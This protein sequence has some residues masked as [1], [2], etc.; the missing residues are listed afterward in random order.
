MS[1][2]EIGERVGLHLRCFGKLY[3]YRN[4]HHRDEN[5]AAASHYLHMR[6][7]GARV[8]PAFNSVFVPMISPYDG[9][10]RQLMRLLRKLRVTVVFPHGQQTSGVEF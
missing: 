5:H 3:N 6:F 7:A 1:L 8:G 9:Y 2:R 4:D 10:G